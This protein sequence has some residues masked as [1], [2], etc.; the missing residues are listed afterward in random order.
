MNSQFKI[1]IEDAVS[2]F[3][4]LDDKLTSARFDVLKAQWR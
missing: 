3:C 4:A 2:N 1:R